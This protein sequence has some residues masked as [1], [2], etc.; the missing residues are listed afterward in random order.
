MRFNNK[1][2]VIYNS[3]ND[4]GELVEDTKEPIKCLVLRHYKKNQRD[5]SEF[6]YKHD[7]KLM[8]AYKS[9]APYSDLFNSDKLKIEYES[10]EY[11]IKIITAINNFNGKTK[12]FE[13]DCDEDQND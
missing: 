12:Y 13:L 7:L 11:T 3:Y 10:R 6:G 5:E 1:A 2:N 8:A 4:F 9:F